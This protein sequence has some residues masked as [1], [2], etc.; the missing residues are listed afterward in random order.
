[1]QN[2]SHRGIIFNIQRFAI[3]DGPGIRT[4]V[5]FKGCPL[6]CWWCHNP[7]S[8]KILPEKFD[9]CNLRRG[10][11]QSFS[12]EKDEIGKEISVDE[13]VNEIV[14]DRMFFDESSGG[15]TFSGGEPL[16]QPEFLIESLKE[17]KS[18]GVHSVVDT[19]GYASSEI[20]NEVAPYTDLFLYDLKLM[21]DDDHE[22]YTGVSNQVTLKNLVSLD[23][24]G[25]KIIIRIPIVPDI[26]NTNENL[27][28]LR[29]FISD[30][31]NVMEINLLP[32]HRVGEGKYAKYDI[33]NKMGDVESPE[34]A[35]L[36]NTKQFFSELNCKVKIGG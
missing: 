15:A 1:M 14:K 24:L 7:E 3:H 26:T 5:F 13:L 36:E 9:G 35:S 32:F 8:H 20:I 33:E 16:M 28:A 21:N 6:R 2:N 23:Q 4:T 25:K 31:K 18:N 19:C 22:K 17:C 30:L 27:F 29:G 10:F 12:M 34:S 11:D